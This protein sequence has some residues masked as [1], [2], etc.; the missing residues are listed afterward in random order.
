[1]KIKQYWC[2]NCQAR[3]AKIPQRCPFCRQ[4]VPEK[5]AIQLAFIETLEQQL[6]ESYQGEMVDSDFYQ[7][8]RSLCQKKSA[9]IQLR[10][11]EQQQKIRE[12][13]DKAEQLAIARERERRKQES[14]EAAQKVAAAIEP[15]QP[16]PEAA[17]PEAILDYPASPPPAAVVETTLAETAALP[18]EPATAPDQIKQSEPVSAIAIKA[19]AARATPDR[20]QPKERPKISDI[21]Q[22]LHDKPGTAKTTPQPRRPGILLTYLTHPAVRE[23][24]LL[25]LG[26]FLIMAGEIFVVSSTWSQM[27]DVMRQIGIFSLLLSSVLLFFFLGRFLARRLQVD[28]AALVLY[29]LALFLLPLTMIVPSQL[30][31][32]RPE[33]AA[34]ATVVALVCAG[35]AGR[36][37]GSFFQPSL[38]PVLRYCFI[39][40]CLAQMLTPLAA[41]LFPIGWVVLAY[42][43]LL[44]VL[45]SWDRVTRSIQVDLPAIAWKPLLF[46]MV[47]SSVGMA[48][49][50]VHLHYCIEI[51]PRPYAYA[52]MLAAIALMLAWQH[53]HLLNIDNIFA[54]LAIISLCISVL[55]IS[56]ATGHLYALLATSA[57]TL[58][59]LA[60][61]TRRSANTYLFLATLL[62]SLI[63]Y[64]LLPA[65]VKQ[66]IL[67]LRN[68][69]GGKLGY[70]RGRLPFSYYGITFLPY[71][72]ILGYLGHRL[73]RWRQLHLLK[74]LQGWFITISLGLLALVKF[75]GHDLRPIFF[76]L[77]IY[78]V[79]YLLAI[80]YLH[81]ALFSYF[82]VACVTLWGYEIGAYMFPSD[83][84]R[85]CLILAL[86]AVWLIGYFLSKM[87]VYWH[88]AQC[89]TSDSV[90][91][92]TTLGT[93]WLFYLLW[94][95]PPATAI[96]YA[97][98]A[99]SL[100]WLAL[101]I[102]YH[103][104]WLWLL[105]FLCLTAAVFALSYR[106]SGISLQIAAA[107]SLVWS[108]ALTIMLVALRFLPQRE[109]FLTW[110][111]RPQISAIWNGEQLLLRPL[112]MMAMLP[113]LA[114]FLLLI[115]S[116]F[117]TRPTPTVLYLFASAPLYAL[118]LLHLS[119]S[120]R[121]GYA[122]LAQSTWL[123][124]LVLLVNHRSPQS[125][126]PPLIVAAICL[127]AAIYL[128][129]LLALATA[130]AIML[131]SSL[132]LFWNYGYNWPQLA[133]I[134]S[135]VA[136]VWAGA[137]YLLQRR[138]R[139]SAALIFECYSLIT[140]TCVVLILTLVV[141]SASYHSYLVVI[142]LILA[143]R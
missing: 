29:F 34:A 2:P 17:T 12:E 77:P 134:Y 21:A 110:A 117:C 133:A 73:H 137:Q 1:M 112:S 41:R 33:L 44:L 121:I 69:L 107:L 63:V 129:Q 101:I 27:S 5:D 130:P 19:P 9:A 49:L 53:H 135:S 62:C 90:V 103:R 58:V 80:R 70:S 35:F 30:L 96:G 31:R 104:R 64:F 61:H 4:E 50:L 128:R 143:W 108:Y 10:L 60:Y 139:N 15:D 55:A 48:A 16:V 116:D 23:N 122:A 102:I 89:V 3:F 120:T 57:M 111:R 106:F 93:G 36:T 75:G 100:L 140:A 67:E 38:A 14:I 65:P 40:L 68:W 52:V 92:L 37:I 66:L 54:P 132:H 79:G 141:L 71:M 94:H 76:T 142:A 118:I 124:L 125:S 85:P 28:S 72:I 32:I 39:P 20:S 115:F 119:R 8:L 83:W 114:A 127:I 95:W 109:K 24:I 136:L 88:N 98:L 78:A 42:L 87:R 59:L 74:A 123:P 138:Q 86:A 43:P 126:L 82:S 18:P 99:A 25:F 13:Q 113:L 97:L 81:L 26:I 11:W 131:L 56:M 84:A 6:L 7:K 46:W 51:A 91:V 22:Y 45:F 47:I 105:F